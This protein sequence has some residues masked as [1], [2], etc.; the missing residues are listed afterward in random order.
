MDNFI[1][2]NTTKLVFGRGTEGQAGEMIREYSDCKKILLV[3][4]SERIKKDGLFDR[5]AASVRAQ[6]M[7]IAELGGV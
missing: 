2:T 3:Y 5:V 6:G 7:E 1:F 4:G